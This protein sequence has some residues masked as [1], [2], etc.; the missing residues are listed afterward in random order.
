MFIQLF[1]NSS[2]LI[3]N[4]S[5]T[6]SSSSSYYVE[7]SYRFKRSSRHVLKIQGMEDTWYCKKEDGKFKKLKVVI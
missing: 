3:L 1:K 5:I 7:K 2:I 4:F 6:S